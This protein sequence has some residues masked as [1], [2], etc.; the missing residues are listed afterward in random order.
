MPNISL[1]SGVAIPLNI[2]FY[3]GW[4]LI[5]LI[6]CVPYFLFILYLFKILFQSKSKINIAII[7]SVIMNMLVILLED[8]TIIKTFLIMIILS[9]LIGIISSKIK[10]YRSIHS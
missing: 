2:I 5:G 10:I 6:L 1:I 7:S 9:L 3:N 8:I 4:G